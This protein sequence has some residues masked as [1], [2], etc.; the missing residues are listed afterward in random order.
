MILSPS[1]EVRE[2]ET[3]LKLRRYKQAFRYSVMKYGFLI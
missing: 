1:I 2:F 3:G